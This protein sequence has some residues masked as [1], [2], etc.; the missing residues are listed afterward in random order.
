ML[1]FK[2]FY[3]NKCFRV[4][5]KDRYESSK[6]INSDELYRRL[7]DSGQILSI[8]QFVYEYS[9]EAEW[10]RGEGSTWFNEADLEFIVNE[11]QY[12]RTL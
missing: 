5:K 4:K 8:S 12:V 2:D 11:P 1:R 9:L 6:V 7:A 10:V 3:T